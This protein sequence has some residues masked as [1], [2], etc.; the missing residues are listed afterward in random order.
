MRDFHKRFFSCCVCV[1]SCGVDQDVSERFFRWG[2]IL[3]SVMEL[4]FLVDSQNLTRK[5]SNHVL[6]SGHGAA[7]PRLFFVGRAV[8]DF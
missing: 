3:L 5:N 4:L 2:N 7:P 6:G 8:A 1:N